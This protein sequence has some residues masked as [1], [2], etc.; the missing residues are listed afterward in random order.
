MSRVWSDEQISAFL[1]GELDA[2]E[3]E[4]MLHDLENNPAVSARV[5]RMSEATKAFVK[6]SLSIDE[7]PMS[8]GLLMALAAPPTAKVIPFRGRSFAATVMEHRA[9]AASLVCAVA[10]WGVYAMVGSANDNALNTGGMIAATSP[11]HRGL[12][13]GATGDVVKVSGAETM[14]PRLTFAKDDGDFCRQF[15]VASREGVTSAI[16]CRDDGVWR[17][18][19]AVYGQAQPG[20]EYTT[21]SGEKAEPLEAFIE[22]FISGDPLDAAAEKAAITNNWSGSPR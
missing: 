16:A 8:E 14:T 21:A 10:A 15:D 1:D 19:V 7:E 12:E 4:D 18:E 13:T 17:T 9:I 3:F 11:L 5:R 6:A 20:E 2:A 22:R